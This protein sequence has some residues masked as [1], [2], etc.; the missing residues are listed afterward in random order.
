MNI[1][2]LLHT[3]LGVEGVES[4]NTFHFTHTEKANVYQVD[5]HFGDEKWGF[6]G[7]HLQSTIDF[8]F[9]MRV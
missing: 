9:V 4:H 5:S 3:R 1:G 2:F 6:V 8:V 7:W